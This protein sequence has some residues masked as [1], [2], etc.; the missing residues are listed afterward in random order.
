MM[1]IL[2]GGLNPSKAGWPEGDLTVTKLVGFSHRIVGAERLWRAAGGSGEMRVTVD[3]GG[4]TFSA[5]GQYRYRLWRVVDTPCRRV[6]FDVVNLSAWIST[7]PDGLFKTEGYDP[8]GSDNMKHLVAA[9]AEADLV[10]AAWGSLASLPAW[11]RN[12]GETVLRAFTRSHDVQCL[13]KTKDGSPRHPSR[14]AY[15]TPLELFRPRR[16]AA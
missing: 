13:G 16:L 5:D 9:L 8:F 6:R 4:A 1:R 10:V 2:F 12:Q 15:A 7:D 11:F 14:N 3:D